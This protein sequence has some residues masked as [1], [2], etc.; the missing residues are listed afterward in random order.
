MTGESK[1]LLKV[2]QPG[3]NVK[4]KAAENLLV[5]DEQASALKRPKPGYDDA[6][7]RTAGHERDNDLLLV[8]TD[9]TTSHKMA[10][11]SHR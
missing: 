9:H 11:Q 10:T 5:F 3:Y 2:L 6:V 8:N 7:I 1:S 4:L